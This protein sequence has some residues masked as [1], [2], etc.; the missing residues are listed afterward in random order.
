[1]TNC[2]YC[3]NPVVWSISKAGKR[4]LANEHRIYNEDG[5]HIKTIHPA[6]R[7]PA[8]AEQKAAIDAQREAEHQ[9]ALQN[10]EIV[11]GQRVV[12]AK[13]R[14]YPI[15]TIG[16]VDWIARHEDKFGVFKVRMVLE[17]GTRIYVNRENIKAA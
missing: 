2:R 9:Q 17:D 7:C 10:G 12:V 15:G 6:H 11:L 16:T 4:Y 3:G 13:G 14:K 1:M 8:T 5:R